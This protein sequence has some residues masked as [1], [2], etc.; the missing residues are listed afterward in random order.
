MTT[1]TN[2]KVAQSETLEPQQRKPQCTCTFGIS[3]ACPLHAKKKR[4]RRPDTVEPTV[5]APESMDNAA[6]TAY[7]HE[8]VHG[9]DDKCAYGGI[10]CPIRR[11]LRLAVDRYRSAAIREGQ[12]E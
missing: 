5:E 12:A 1:N 2:Q 10:G 9:S 7:L 4:K 11:D 3:R 8:I 6:F